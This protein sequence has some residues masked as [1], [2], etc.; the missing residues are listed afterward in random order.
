MTEQDLF[1]TRPVEIEF[2]NAL[3]RFI[4]LKVGYSSDKRPPAATIPWRSFKG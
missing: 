1:M 2:L 4:D 3:M